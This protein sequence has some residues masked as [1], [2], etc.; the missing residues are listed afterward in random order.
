MVVITLTDVIFPF[1]IASFSGLMVFFFILKDFPSSFKMKIFASAF[2]TLVLIA[3]A[4]FF[5]QSLLVG[6][7]LV[8]SWAVGWLIVIANY[9]ADTV[10]PDFESDENP[11]KIASSSTT[12]SGLMLTI[13]V[14]I[15]GSV[16]SV[17]SNSVYKITMVA[18]AVPPLI[19]AMSFV[20][21]TFFLTKLELSPSSDAFEKQR[22]I[23]KVVM[24]WRIGQTIQMSTL[25]SIAFFVAVAISTII[26]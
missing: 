6:V 2:V 26:P 14:F 3:T 22:N 7:I 12:M 15:L 4:F 9:G 23:K 25:I 16:A 20:M 1:I 21:C 19:G 11:V 24:W 18:F 5:T 8:I 10:L 13:V 17:L